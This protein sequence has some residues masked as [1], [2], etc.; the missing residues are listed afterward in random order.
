MYTRPRP[1]IYTATV[2]GVYA[3]CRRPEG[4]R[5]DKIARRPSPDGVG[6]D[7]VALVD[8]TSVLSHSPSTSL[9]GLV[10]TATDTDRRVIHDDANTYHVV[11]GADGY[12]SDDGPLAATGGAATGDTGGEADDGATDDAGADDGEGSDLPDGE[13]D[14]A[15]DPP[16]GEMGDDRAESGEDE[17]DTDDRAESEEE[18]DDTDDR[19][20]KAEPGG[21]DDRPGEITGGDDPDGLDSSDG[22]DDGRPAISVSPRCRTCR[23]RRRGRCRS[24]RGT[25]RV[26]S[27]GR[28]RRRF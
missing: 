6:V 19:T 15:D 14:D 24:P 23:W 25:P 18:A 28:S 21:A 7:V 4:S 10:D 8:V 20:G 12:R 3:A 5:T 27:R 1:D 11:D 9:A 22:S 13:C 16:D 2:E 26:R 17:G